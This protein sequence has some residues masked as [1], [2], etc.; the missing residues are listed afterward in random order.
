MGL[1]L[2]IHEVYK[3]SWARI[4]EWINDLYLFCKTGKYCQSCLL[5]F[6]SLVPCVVQKKIGVQSV[7]L[8]NIKGI[9]GHLWHIVRIWKIFQELRFF[10]RILCLSC[11]VECTRQCQ[12]YI[13]MFW[14]SHDFTFLYDHG[15]IPIR[16]M[17]PRF[18]TILG[19]A[20]KHIV[21]GFH[22]TALAVIN[23]SCFLHLP[24]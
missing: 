22:Y 14:V 8:N 23:A 10:C 20:H 21:S 3:M 5:E 4:W 19:G 16:T 9:S 7:I 13:P 24:Y 2:L 11:S 15:Q 18:Y 1:N 12:F 17:F 6:L